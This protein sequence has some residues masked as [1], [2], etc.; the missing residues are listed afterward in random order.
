MCCLNTGAGVV[1]D[2]E[3]KGH[4]GVKAEKKKRREERRHNT[5]AYAVHSSDPEKPRRW[6]RPR[7]RVKSVDHGDAC[8]QK[9]IQRMQRVARQVDHASVNLETG[10]SFEDDG[11]LADPRRT[12]SLP[13]ELPEARDLNL[14]VCEPVKETEVLSSETPG[15]AVAQDAETPRLEDSQP[16]GEASPRDVD[17]CKDDTAQAET[18]DAPNL[19]AKDKE[20]LHRLQQLAEEFSKVK[21]EN[22]KLQEDLTKHKRLNKNLRKENRRLFRK[23]SSG[24]DMQLASKDEDDDPLQ[25]HVIQQLQSLQVEKAKLVQ[26]NCQ[27]SRDNQSLHELLHYAMGHQDEYDSCSDYETG[28]ESEIH[29]NQN[30]HRGRVDARDEYRKGDISAST[31]SLF[32]SKCFVASSGHASCL[33]NT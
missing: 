33:L 16:S 1:H 31:S 28:H 12:V 30:N 32:D 6:Q 14:Q 11:E 2:S 3:M 24:S 22:D 23:Q 18:E 5:R 25:Q 8:G 4:G 26:E 21:E 27:L 9:R 29:E 15:K 7:R 17:Q 19:E 13:A 20:E 10:F